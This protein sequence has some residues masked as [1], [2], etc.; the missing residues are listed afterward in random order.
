MIYFNALWRTLFSF[1]L[2]WAMT[3][4]MGKKQISQLTLFDYITGITVGSLTANL[5]ATPETWRPIA[6]S[7]A[8]WTGLTYTFHRLAQQGRSISRFLDDKPTI[9]I[10]NGKVMEENLSRMRLTIQDLTAMLRVKGWFDLAQ[11]EFALLETNGDLSVLPCSQYRPLQ[12]HDMALST[13][14]EGLSTQ[15]MQEARPISHGL[16][17]VGLDEAWLRA[18]LDRLGIRRD[19]VFSAWLASNGTLVV[20]RYRDQPH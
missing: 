20:D 13:S 15:V 16:R 5:I 7:L 6:M 9:L 8:I 10:R 2:L 4:I 14:Y 11:V 18:E 17:E 12:P 1:A 3:R 19:E